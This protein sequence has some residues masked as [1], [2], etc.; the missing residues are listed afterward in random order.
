MTPITTSSSDPAARLRQSSSE[1]A[2]SS[3]SNNSRRGEGRTRTSS[4]GTPS[5]RKVDSSQTHA[6]ASIQSSLFV[7]RLSITRPT[8][9]P[10]PI[11]PISPSPTRRHK[12]TPTMPPKSILPPVIEKSYSSGSVKR[13]AETDFVEGDKTPPRDPKES[14]ATFAPEPK[15][16]LVLVE[17]HFSIFVTHSTF[18]AQRLSASSL[19]AHAPS[20]YNRSKRVRLTDSSEGGRSSSSRPGLRANTSEESPPN[21]KNT[22]SWSSRGSH[23]PRPASSYTH[24]REGPPLARSASRASHSAHGHRAPSRRS[25]SQVSIPISAL[26][27]PHA[28]SIT[29]SGKFHMRDPRKP[30]RIQNTPWSLSFPTSWEAGQSRWET[31]SWV[32]R[33]GSP[34]HAWF[35]F[36]GFVLFPLWWVAAFI[37]TPMTRRLGGTDAEKGVMLDDPQV[38]HGSSAILNIP[39]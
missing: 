22:G 36:I 31:H 11:S 32:A 27:S 12:S 6:F 25:L 21:S 28:P 39:T 4:S 34:L 35:F 10:S 13:K 37:S 38:E 29:H 33:G 2:G 20:S 3:K 5:Q 23:G 18:S 30:A 19:L 24:H 9:E 15:S 8:P 7:P 16:T 17:V 14:R 1:S 26:V